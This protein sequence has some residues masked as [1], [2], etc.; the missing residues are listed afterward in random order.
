MERKK[1]DGICEY[2]GEDPGK[3]IVHPAFYLVRKVLKVAQK[4]GWGAC[5]FAFVVKKNER[6]R[7][8]GRLCVPPLYFHLMLSIKYV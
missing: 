5:E 2:T 8:R 7:S 1:H 3:K 6:R 4:S